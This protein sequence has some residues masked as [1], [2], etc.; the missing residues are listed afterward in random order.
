MHQTFRHTY[1]H[2]LSSMAS[3]LIP[4]GHGSCDPHFAQD[5]GPWIAN[6]S[7]K[8]DVV[9]ESPGVG[10]SGSSTESQWSADVVPDIVAMI[11]DRCPAAVGRSMTTIQETEEGVQYFLGQAL[12]QIL[13]TAPE[14]LGDASSCRLCHTPLRQV[15]GHRSRPVREIFGD[16]TWAGVVILCPM[17][18]EVPYRPSRPWDP[19]RRRQP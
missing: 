2:L 1:L 11:F 6:N 7:S 16:Y 12:M 3:L 13:V 10:N 15:D 18:R 9:T 17:A 8:M 19:A 4:D 5:F 14:D